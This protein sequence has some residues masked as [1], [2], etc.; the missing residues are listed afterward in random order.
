V[1]PTDLI[2]VGCGLMGGRH[3]R[4]YGALE[5]V[6][7]GTLRLRAVCDLRPEAAERVAAEA[8][9]LLG[10][11]PLV[12]RNAEEALSKTSVAA[13]DV[14]TEPRT[15]PGVVIPLLEAGVHVQ[16]EKPLAVTVAAGQQIVE[17]A[18]QAG[19][20]LAVAENYRRDPMNRLLKH[21]LVSGAVG[22]STF[23]SELHVGDGSRVLVSPWR[24]DWRHGGI[25]LDMGVHYADMI[26][27]LMGP[28]ATIAAQS[29]KV[30]ETRLWTTPEGET[31]EAAVECDDVYSALLTFESG[32]TGM[33]LM[34]YGAA[35]SSQWQRTVYGSEGSVSGPPD[36]SGQPVR[37]QR[38]KE[39]LE[40]EAMVAALPDFRL[41][42]TE[43]RMFGERPGTC[44]VEFKVM[45]ANL[46]GIETANFLDAVREGREPE[47][48]GAGD[49]L[50]ALAL[51]MAL[52]ESAA[53]GGTPVRVDDVLSGKV[54][55]FQDA[56][57]ET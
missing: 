38:G 51:V 31:Q 40:G 17:A 7:P 54:R 49:G 52:M 44:A 9:T 1:E 57:L 46:I 29:R 50:H 28:V 47:V 32:V 12:C 19:R 15:H 10:Y 53:L 8:E 21:A 13:A 45:D 20:V 24:H 25:A 39:T 42:A 23:L 11:R 55:A 27:Y 36:R 5:A 30:R 26:E 33:W 56:R 14:V 48:T 18:R 4:G 37:L 3:L 34:H 22:T 41:S 35:G 43:A 6:R 2:L 16:V